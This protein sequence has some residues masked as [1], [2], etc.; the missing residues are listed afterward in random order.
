MVK[1]GGA[2]CELK[3]KKRHTQDKINTNIKIKG[4]V[5]GNRKEIP[6]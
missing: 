4:E 3:E 5:N 6:R 1:K 2:K